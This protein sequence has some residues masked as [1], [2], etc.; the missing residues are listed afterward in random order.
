MDKDEFRLALLEW[1]GMIRLALLDLNAKMAELIE[2][3]KHTQQ[4]GQ[5]DDLHH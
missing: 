1:Q 3:T 4:G 2:L 5:A